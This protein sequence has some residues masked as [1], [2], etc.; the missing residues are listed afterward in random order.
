[1]PGLAAKVFAFRQDWVDQ[2]GFI[3]VSDILRDGLLMEEQLFQA[4]LADSMLGQLAS[5][6]LS[7]TAELSEASG[8]VT[9]AESGGVCQ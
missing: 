7:T 2:F 3:C 6:E 5:Q 4:V 8:S 1:M 9:L